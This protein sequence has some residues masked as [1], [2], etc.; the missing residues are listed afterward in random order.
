MISSDQWTLLVAGY[1]AV[2]ST[3]ALFLEVRRWFESGPRIR[4]SLMPVA[5][6][7]GGL[8][9]DATYIGITV[10]NFGELPT[11]ITHVFLKQYSGWWGRLRRRAV[12]SAIVPNPS[13]Y[14]LQGM[15][16]P[17]TLQTGQIW[18]AQVS[19]NAEL[20]DRARSRQ[21]HVGLVCSHSTTPILKRV[22]LPTPD[23]LG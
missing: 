18:H 22:K 13:P 12:F 3:G 23:G 7:F 8:D 21:L 17:H 2:V 16:P 9:D 14:G 6:T 1:A 10:T 15:N 20:I 4:L 19:Y 11:T 5:K